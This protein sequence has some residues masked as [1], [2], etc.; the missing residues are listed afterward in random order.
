MRKSVLQKVRNKMRK[1]QDKGVR[2]SKIIF[3]DRRTIRKKNRSD[4][5]RRLI[6]KIKIMIL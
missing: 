1:I 3:E 5:L 6:L 4:K 2:V